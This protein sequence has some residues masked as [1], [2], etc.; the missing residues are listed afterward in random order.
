MRKD[1]GY[2]MNTLQLMKKKHAIAKRIN[3]E[4]GY[5]GTPFAGDVLQDDW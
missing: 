3:E 5:E 2:G 1:Y 4:V